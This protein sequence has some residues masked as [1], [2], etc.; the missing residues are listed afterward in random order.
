MFIFQRLHQASNELSPCWIFLVSSVKRAGSKPVVGGGEL[1]YIY[2]LYS[3]GDR[4][5][6]CVTPAFISLGVDISPST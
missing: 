2:K 6:L 1:S 3:V 4:M 5:E